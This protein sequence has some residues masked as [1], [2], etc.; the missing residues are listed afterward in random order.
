MGIFCKAERPLL[1]GCVKLLEHRWTRC[2][3]LICLKIK[4]RLIVKILCVLGSNFST[5]PRGLKRVGLYKYLI[6]SKR[7]L[8]L[9]RKNFRMSCSIL[10]D[11]P[12][13]TYRNLIFQKIKLYVTVKK[14]FIC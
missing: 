5:H 4:L 9:T 13:Y 6:I 7:N 14:L 10:F 8:C 11:P 12:L 2:I 1:F 3:N